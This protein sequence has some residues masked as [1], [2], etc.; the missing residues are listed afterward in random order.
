MGSVLGVPPNAHEARAGDNPRDHHVITIM[1][2]EFVHN[3][4]VTTFDAPAEPEPSIF[5]SLTLTG[6]VAPR[7]SASPGPAARG[8]LLLGVHCYK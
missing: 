3:H 2:D 1:S 6:S 7:G 5:P 8:W 4:L